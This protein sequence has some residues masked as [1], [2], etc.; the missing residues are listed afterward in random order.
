MNRKEMEKD[1]YIVSLLE[2]T[3]LKK[4]F[5]KGFVF[6][7]RD[8]LS[9]YVKGYVAPLYFFKEKPIKGVYGWLSDSGSDF[10][11]SANILFD[12]ITWEDEEPT[13]I[14]DII[15]CFELKL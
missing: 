1:K 14:A 6:V 12:F 15:H 9:E 11:L 5:S 8:S 10:I 3:L 7:A 4:V 13:L 2:Y